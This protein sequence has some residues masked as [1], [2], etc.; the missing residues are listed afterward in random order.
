MRHL[1]CLLGLSLFP[2]LA[3]GEQPLA[4]PSREDLEKWFESD[5]P[6]DVS[7]VN[8]GQLDF[9][10]QAPDGTVIHHHQNKVRITPESLEGGWAQLEQCHDNLDQAS[11]MQIAFRDGYVKD[12]RVTEQRNIGKVW[13]EG[14]SVQLTK[15]GADAHLCLQARTR[16]LRIQDDGT[17]LLVNGPYMRKFLDGYYPMRVSMQIEYPADL[18]KVSTITPAVQPGFAVQQRDGEVDFEAIFEGELR[19]AIQFEEL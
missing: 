12:M 18:L 16:A 17:F 8:E 9:L 13:V 4:E 11:A 14:S 3:F 2:L 1:A 19:T 6:G 5:S 15:V 7:S 10:A